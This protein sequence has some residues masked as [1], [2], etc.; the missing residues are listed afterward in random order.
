MT[1]RRALVP[2]ATS[3]SLRAAVSVGKGKA[4][5]S[6]HAVGHDGGVANDGGTAIQEVSVS[7]SARRSSARF[8][9]D[10]RSHLFRAT[11]RQGRWVGTSI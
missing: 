4:V 6:R 10:Q 3:Q 2:T 1:A 11:P 9:I 5:S 8:R 7:R